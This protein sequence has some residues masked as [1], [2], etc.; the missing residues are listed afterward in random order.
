[1][2]TRDQHVISGDTTPCF[3]QSPF[4]ATKAPCLL[5]LMYITVTSLYPKHSRAISYAVRYHCAVTPVLYSDFCCRHVIVYL[6]LSHVAQDFRAALTL[7]ESAAII[8]STPLP[9]AAPLA[10]AKT[11]AATLDWATVADA[12]DLWMLT[13]PTESDQDDTGELTCACSCCTLFSCCSDPCVCS[14]AVYRDL[15]YTE[16]VGE[17]CRN[18]TF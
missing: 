18:L 1:M 7:A 5:Y 6:L 8:G 4:A 16:L 9:Y 14:D 17:R 11:A 12:Y 2:S 10:I 13:R 15:S 3:P